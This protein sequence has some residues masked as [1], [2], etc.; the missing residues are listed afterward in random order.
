M[1]APAWGLYG[2]PLNENH[3]RERKLLGAVRA[4]TKEEA[5]KIFV[6]AQE[7][8]AY[9]FEDGVLI[10]LIPETGERKAE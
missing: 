2:Y 7:N 3:E 8:P 6:R 5:R 1:A 4:Y 10:E 9:G